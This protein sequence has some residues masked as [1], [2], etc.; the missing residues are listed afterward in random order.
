MNDYQKIKDSKR[1]KL[2]DLMAAFLRYSK[3]KVALLM[4]GLQEGDSKV[5]SAEASIVRILNELA[6]ELTGAPCSDLIDD[7]EQ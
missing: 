2:H 6:L 3:Q 4:M 1:E 5:Q 7:V